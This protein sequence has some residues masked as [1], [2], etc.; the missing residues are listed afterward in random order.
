M[1]PP[2]NISE[3]KS[4]KLL[5]IKEVRAWPGDEV[6]G[7]TVRVLGRIRTAEVQRDKIIIDYQNHSILVDVKLLDRES[8]KLFAYGRLLQFFGEVHT[9]C[10]RT[11]ILARSCRDMS[12]LDTDMFDRCLKIRRDFE[13]AILDQRIAANTLP[14][15]D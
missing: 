8:F 6:H 15:Q 3:L 4:G 7:R 1:M 13:T 14:Q 10:D 12:S 11:C 2:G 5:H 9:E